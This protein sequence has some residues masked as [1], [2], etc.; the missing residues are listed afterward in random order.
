MENQ[1]K[2]QDSS[3]RKATIPVKKLQTKEEGFTSDDYSQ[4][5]NAMDSLIQGRSSIDIVES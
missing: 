1:H 4:D 2:K 3:S 5:N